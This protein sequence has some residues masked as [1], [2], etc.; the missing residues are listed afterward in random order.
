MRESLP[1]HLIAHRRDD[2]IFLSLSFFE[3][4][5]GTSPLCNIGPMPDETTDQMHAGLV[6][7][8]RAPITSYSFSSGPHTLT[9][10]SMSLSVLTYA[11]SERKE[12]RRDE[13]QR[14]TLANAKLQAERDINKLVRVMDGGGVVEKQKGH[15]KIPRRL[16]DN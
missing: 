12:K 6:H 10:L 7:H 1:Q 3:S 13:N 4:P 5:P 9:H 15:A 11:K 8:F 16:T 2:K 14:M